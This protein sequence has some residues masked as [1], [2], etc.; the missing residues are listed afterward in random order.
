MGPRRAAGDRKCGP[1]VSRFWPSSLLNESRGALRRCVERRWTGFEI[2]GG[3]PGQSGDS[4]P[5]RPRL[6]R[7]RVEQSLRPP[8]LGPDLGHGYADGARAHSNTRSAL[9]QRV[10]MPPRASGDPPRAGSETRPIPFPAVRPERGVGARSPRARPVSARGLV[11]GPALSRDESGRRLLSSHSL[12]R[13]Q[14][15]EYPF[16]QPSEAL[17]QRGGSRLSRGRP[18]PGLR[19]PQYCSRSVNFIHHAR[20]SQGTSKIAIRT[21]WIPGILVRARARLI[22]G[23][24]S[25]A[26]LEQPHRGPVRLHNRDRRL[27]SF[28]WRRSSFSS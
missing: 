21:T 18:R 23:G 26:F 3:L 20:V 25:I 13:V 6:E 2:V 27:M 5:N 8:P 19:A 9:A 1:G 28:F 17:D 10:P 16:A 22:A 12:E 11:P 24:Y 14:A 4:D 7:R 15:F